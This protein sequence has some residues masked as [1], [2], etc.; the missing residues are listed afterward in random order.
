VDINQLI[1]RTN[2]FIVNPLILLLMAVAV[3]VFFWGVFEFISKSDSD[4]AREKGK[5]NMLWGIVGL[6]IMV[7]VF[8][9]IQ[10]ILGTFGITPPPGVLP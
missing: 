4:E 7:A 5:R 1:Y 9:I 2:Q 10:I 6:F 8:G 3:L